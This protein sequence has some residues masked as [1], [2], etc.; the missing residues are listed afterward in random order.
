MSSLRFNEYLKERD[1]GLYNEFKFLKKAGNWIKNNLSNNPQYYDTASA[2]PAARLSPAQTWTTK[3]LQGDASEKTKGKTVPFRMSDLTNLKNAVVGY[4]GM[5]GNF[6]EQLGK[7]IRTKFSKEMSEVERSFVEKV[8][9]PV[10]KLYKITQWIDQMG[11]RLAQYKQQRQRRRTEA[12]LIEGVKV[13]HQH[14]RQITQAILGVTQAVEKWVH[15]ESQRLQ[16]PAIQQIYDTNLSS[17]QTYLMQQVAWLD[18]KVTELFKAN[19]I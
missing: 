4:Q 8:G 3:Q 9:S 6:L 18:Q 5:M 17:K 1:E 11:Q 14:F 15:D 12:V 13:S 16:D 2:E 10:Q 19:N 7:Y